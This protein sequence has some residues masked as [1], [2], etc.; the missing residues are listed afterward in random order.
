MIDKVMER[1]EKVPSPKQSPYSWGL[2]CFCASRANES[3]FPQAA[4]PANG[5][6]Q[7]VGWTLRKLLRPFLYT[8]TVI[9]R[10]DVVVQHLIHYLLCERSE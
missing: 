7:S 8:Y 1:G 6:D 10:G 9:P 2:A 5:L 3:D 4:S